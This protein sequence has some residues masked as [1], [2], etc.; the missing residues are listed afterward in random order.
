MAVELE[1]PELAESV[2]EGEIVKWLVNEGD[3]V[4]LD[5]L[6]VEVMTDKVTVEVP[7]P[8][9]GILLKQVA[10]EGEVV[11]IGKPIAIFGKEG[12]S[13]DDQTPTVKL[14]ASAKP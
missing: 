6:L 7:S 4:E 14:T 11:G 10:K 3:R 13:L 1:M 8:Y 2:I 5:Q 9:A 12:E